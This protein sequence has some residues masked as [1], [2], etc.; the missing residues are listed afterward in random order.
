MS[1]K[2][3]AV[4]RSL[5]DPDYRR[6]WVREHVAVGLAFQLRALRAD[7]E[8]TQTEVGERSEM[9]QEMLSQWENPNYGKYTLSTL[10]RL[11]SAY[12][13]GLLVRFVPFSEMADW[14]VDLTPDRLA[15]PKYSDDLAAA[16]AREQEAAKAEAEGRS[17]QL[18]LLAESK[19]ETRQSGDRI[20]V[21]VV[22]D[23]RARTATALND[24]QSFRGLR[25][26]PTP[27]GLVRGKL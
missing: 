21:Q 27:S 16:E 20:L 26:Q 2:K 1:A 7:R 13:V 6:D 19:K 11:A 25:N 12:D 18:A 8:W 5:Q 10:Q 17:M 3:L 9:K 22:S 14:T 23:P 24:R 15:P 4:L